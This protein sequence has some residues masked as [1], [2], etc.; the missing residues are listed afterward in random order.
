MAG[1]Y[2]WQFP[3]ECAH[4]FFGSNCTCALTCALFI[5]IGI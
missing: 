1:T 3:D 5:K 4:I 2:H